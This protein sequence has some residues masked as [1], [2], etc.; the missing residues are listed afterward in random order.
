L[1]PT[2]TAAQAASKTPNFAR[3]GS[4][5]KGGSVV[6]TLLL[7]AI[8]VGAMVLAPAAG[9]QNRQGPVVDPQ[10]QLT[11]DVVAIHPSP[12]GATGGGIMPLPKGSGYMARG[13]SVKT[14]MAVMYRVPARQIEG[15]PGWFASEL[16]DVEARADRGGY[17][18]DEL[19]AMFKNLLKDRFGLQF[20]IETREGPVYLLTVAKGGVKMKD[21]GAAGDLKVPIIPRGPGEFV[22]TKVPMEYL[23]WFFGGQ[24]PQG[25]PRPVIDQTG[26]KDVYDFQLSFLPDLPPGVSPDGL[27]PEVRTRPILSDAVEDQLGL[28]LKPGKGPVEY[29]VVDHVNEPSAN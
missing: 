5:V 7:T 9:G 13:M 2:S 25:D 22:G 18:I 16:F 28:M 12:S 27:P 4:V 15:G 24:A 23:C 8:A 26:L 3:G 11:F 1:P 10:P 29:Y 17:S 21:D 14:M 19:H 20:H 6:R